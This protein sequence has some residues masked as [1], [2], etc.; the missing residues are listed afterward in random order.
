M[1]V[2]FRIKIGTRR[3]KDMA[4]LVPPELRDVNWEWRRA[5]TGAV[6]PLRSME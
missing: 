1:L 6:V 2:R 4:F 5:D 3:E